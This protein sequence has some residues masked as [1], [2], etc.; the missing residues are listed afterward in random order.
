MISDDLRV[1]C[2]VFV[3]LSQEKKNIVEEIG[4]I[5]GALGERSTPSGVCVA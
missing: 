3:K 5:M 2:D 1:I 4:A